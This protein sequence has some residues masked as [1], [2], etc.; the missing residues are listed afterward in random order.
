M[1]Q[2]QKKEV[3]KFIEDYVNRLMFLIE[4]ERGVFHSVWELGINKNWK[5]QK[6]YMG[7][8]PGW[9]YIYITGF[10]ERH[11]KDY[12]PK[13]RLDF[14]FDQLFEVFKIS[15]NE[16]IK[17]RDKIKELFR[18]FCAQADETLNSMKYTKR[19]NSLM[20]RVAEIGNKEE[21]KKAQHIIPESNSNRDDKKKRTPSLSL[22][23]KVRRFWYDHAY[24]LKKIITFVVILLFFLFL[25]SKNQN[26][27]ETSKE[28]IWE[29]KEKISDY[30]FPNGEET[31][32]ETEDGEDNFVYTGREIK[33]L[34]E[35]SWS[36]DY[37]N[38]LQSK[39]EKIRLECEELC[40]STQSEF[41]ERFRCTGNNIMYCGCITKEKILIKE[42]GNELTLQKKG[43]VEK[44]VYGIQ[45]SSNDLLKDSLTINDKTQSIEQLVF[46]K[47]NQERSKY[48]LTQLELDDGLSEVARDHSLDM[49]QRNFFSHENPDGE[50]PTDRAKRHGLETEVSKNGYIWIGIAENIGQM[51]TGN[52]LGYGYVSSEE[53]IASAMINGWMNS[54]GHRANILNTN[55]DRIGVGVATSG[56]IYYL[57]Q[58][59][60]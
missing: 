45:P 27:L 37:Y 56:S 54:P 60:Q 43:F 38:T 34:R 49:V 14:E 16:S 26:I 8:A 19:F 9:I 46:F 50:D 4:D 42:P 12:I 29:I 59:F 23:D 35:T 53:D 21:E 11:N 3:L 39:E 13:K 18:Q 48:G 52:V 32:F 58:N 31:I 7:T 6:E 25:Y 22:Y 55:Y 5:E 44:V 51:P 33:E 36:C 28:K 17:N 15:F 1:A 41:D 40:T 2:Y 20:S 10:N 24:Y 47:T 30:F 57:T